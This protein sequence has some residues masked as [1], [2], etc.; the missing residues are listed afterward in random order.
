[1]ARLQ[2]SG[3]IGQ[4]VGIKPSRAELQRQEEARKVTAKPQAPSKEQLEYQQKQAEYQAKLKEYNDFQAGYNWG[5]RNVTMPRQFMTKAQFE[6]Y[7]AGQENKNY[8]SAISRY[9]SALKVSQQEIT[10]PDPFSVTGPASVFSPPKEGDVGFIGPVRPDVVPS[11][12]VGPLQPGQR[13]EA[14]PPTAPTPSPFG[15]YTAIT[16]KASFEKYAKEYGREPSVKYFKEPGERKTPPPETSVISATSPSDFG[17]S[18]QDFLKTKRYEVSPYFKRGTISPGVSPF[19]TYGDLQTTIDLSKTSSMLKVQTELYQKLKP[20]EIQLQSQI[21]LGVIGLEEAEEQFMFKQKEL[22]GSDYFKGKFEASQKGFMDIPGIDT[23]KYKRDKEAGMFFLKSAAASNPFTASIMGASIS[24]EDPLIIKDVKDPGKSIIVDYKP[25]AEATL[26]FATGGIYAASKLKTIE[27][28]IVAGQ[29]EALQSKKWDLGAS[30]MNF[31]K[32]N[33]DYLVATREMGGLKQT[34]EIPTA[35]VQ[36]SKEGKS[37]FISKGFGNIRTTGKLDWNIIGGAKDTKVFGVKGFNVEGFGVSSQAKDIKLL[38]DFKTPKGPGVL[39]L[40]APPIQAYETLSIS[41]ITPTKESMFF[42]QTPSTRKES[43]LIGKDIGKQFFK[44]LKIGGKSTYDITEGT[45]IRVKSD[46]FYTQTGAGDTFYT[47]VLKS[48][49]AKDKGFSIITGGKS[50]TP[51]SKIW[52][53][54]T[55][56]SLTSLKADIIPPATKMFPKIKVIGTTPT[57]YTQTTKMTQP[58]IMKVP[59]SKAKV[60]TSIIGSTKISSKSFQI[61]LTIT[62]TKTR[63]KPKQIVIPKSSQLSRQLSSQKQKVSTLQVT[64]QMTKQLSP[65]RPGF[66]P[67]VNIRTPGWTPGFG[68]GGGWGWDFDFSGLGGKKGR[69][70]PIKKRTPTSIFRVPSLVALGRGI[71]ATGIKGRET[72]FS[73]RPII[74][75]STKKK[76]RKK[77]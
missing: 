77:K 73:I 39:E 29:F 4:Q 46:L 35:T 9:D 14:P 37:L 63:Q 65:F 19:Y 21:D 8:Q 54:P 64:K 26:Y 69:R 27:Q 68:I 10:Q 41:K 52:G 59:V 18:E 36:V 20:T 56:T 61:P 24:K 7:T 45:S 70:K 34:L 1:M 25:S 11:T 44:N 43:I 67:K 33:I 40:K 17:E 31:K 50:V 74:I 57:T 75:K 62:Q 55:T 2:P 15:E 6:G 12:F 58:T 76:R 13:R 71:T 48:P 51:L 72:P 32:G 53:S 3:R 5:S 42:Y 38:M 30:T 23:P 28:S 66:A 47:K 22:I 49:E 60:D 16:D